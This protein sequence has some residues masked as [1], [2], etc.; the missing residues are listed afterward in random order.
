MY[1]KTSKRLALAGALIMLVLY[2]CGGENNATTDPDQGTT[3]TDQGTM[4]P[5]SGSTMLD[6]AKDEDSG[7]ADASPDLP[8]PMPDMT[9]A[10]MPADMQGGEDMANNGPV[11]YHSHI[12]PILNNSCMRCHFDGGQGP[13]DFSDPAYVVENAE[14]LE[15]R[16][17]AGEMPPPVADPD[18]RDYLSSDALSM[19]DEAKA[20]LK[21]WIE[22]GKPLGE[23]DGIP[24]A[25]PEA[26]TF[27]NPDLEMRLLAPYTPTYSDANNPNNEY[28]CFA[29]EHNQA[30]RFYVTALHPIIDRPEIVHHVVLAKLPRNQLPADTTSMTGQ[31]CI[32]DMGAIQNM[33]GAWAPGMDPITFDGA[34]VEIGANDVFIIQMHY[35]AD[36]EE[37]MG[38]ADQS[39]YAMKIASDVKN[40]IQMYPLGESGF[41][42]P[43]GEANH[44]ERGNISLPIPVTL[45]GAFPHM[46]KIGT[47]YEMSVNVAGEDVCLLDGPKYDFNNQLTYIFDEPMY[48]PPGSEISFTCRWNNSPSNP[49]LAGQTITDVGYGER[50]D[51]EMCFAF[52]YVSTGRRIE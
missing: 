20:T 21:A 43:A 18:C 5:D 50:T 24:A 11:T 46:H 16:V 13:S 28:R 1:H 40:K 47:S 52:S 6:M 49:V 7:S 10:D 15:S 23:D 37:N 9:G 36:A 48:I 42:I 32:R 3:L 45:W 31:D 35:F 26:S 17:S 2:G 39:G 4:E 44:E 8:A 41:T 38:I 19:S 33:V 14:W 34:G 30:E 27:E 29:L 51:E 12:K 25:P 22:A